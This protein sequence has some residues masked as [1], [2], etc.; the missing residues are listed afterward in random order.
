MQYIP[1]DGDIIELNVSD[2]IDTYDIHTLQIDGHWLAQKCPGSEICP[3][4]LESK[5]LFDSK[6]PKNRKLAGKLFATPR[7]VFRISVNGFTEYHMSKQIFL[8]YKFL[9]DNHTVKKLWI[10][11][12]VINRHGWHCYN[13]SCFLV[14][15]EQHIVPIKYLNYI[16]KHGHEFSLAEAN[17]WKEPFNG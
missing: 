11:F 3:L 8:A 4:C 12:R 9:L 7:Y 14:N 13:S 17:E 15:N 16:E 5:K 10:K 6:D 1:Q 2:I